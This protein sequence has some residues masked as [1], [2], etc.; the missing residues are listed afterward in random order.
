MKTI[1]GVREKVAE[2]TTSWNENNLEKIAISISKNVDLI[3]GID[4]LFKDGYKI[5]KE[6]MISILNSLKSKYEIILLDTSSECFMDYTKELV[7]ESDF[8]VFLAEANLIELKKSR[9]L[10]DIYINNWK[11]NKEKIKIVF[12]KY[13]KN[14][15]DSNILKNLFC[16][17]N[18][19]GFIKANDNY[20]YMINKNYNYFNKEL[21]NEYQKIIQKIQ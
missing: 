16:D 18:I 2:E 5:E 11:I 1:F 10:L 15:I 7:N 8:A 4:I 3:C 20:N 21:K 14:S 13:N 17:F 19:L 9:K 12:N 6:K